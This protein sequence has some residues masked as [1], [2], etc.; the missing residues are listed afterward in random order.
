MYIRGSCLAKIGNMLP[1]LVWRVQGTVSKKTFVLYK[2]IHLFLL[3]H[4]KLFIGN[5]LQTGYNS[6]IINFHQRHYIVTVSYEFIDL[7][8]EV[9][10][11]SVKPV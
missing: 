9:Q 1:R 3:N 11:L 4:P 6:V 10:E 7:W 5:S 2:P 8:N